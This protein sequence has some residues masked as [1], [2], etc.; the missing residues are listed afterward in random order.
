MYSFQFLCDMNY[1][2]WS[3]SVMLQTVGAMCQECMSHLEQRIQEVLD[4]RMLFAC[5]LFIL[6]ATLACSRESLLLARYICLFTFQIHSVSYPLLAVLH[7]TKYFIKLRALKVVV[8]KTILDLA[9][10]LFQF[11]LVYYCFSSLFVSVYYLFQF[12]ICFRLLS[13]QFIVVLVYYFF[14][15]IHIF[16]IISELFYLMLLWQLE[17]RLL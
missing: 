7:L 14:Q 12:I 3:T 13:F 9:Y 1:F 16:T 10:Y 6:S 8:S 2:L 15:F 17:S 11:I 5:Q 4:G